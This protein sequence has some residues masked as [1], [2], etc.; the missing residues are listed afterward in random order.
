MCAGG[1]LF[2]EVAARGGLE[3]EVA[4][5]TFQQYILGLDY[6]HRMGVMHRDIKLEK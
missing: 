4:R 2:E 6:C 5:V 1:S 3:E